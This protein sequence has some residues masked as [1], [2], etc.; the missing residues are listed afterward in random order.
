MAEAIIR[1]MLANK[2]CL[3]EM[4]VA[5]DVN[6][7]RLAQLKK[8]F[9]I[10]IQHDI[11]EVLKTTRLLLLAVKPQQMKELIE[12]MQT[13]IVPERHVLIS[14]AAGLTTELLESWLGKPVKVVRVMPNTPARF[15]CG[16]TAYCLGR[17]AGEGE[18]LLAHRIF[19][20]VGIVVR[21][22]EKNMNAITALSGS[23]PAY[24]F[25]LCEILGRA[26][27]QLGLDWETAHTLARQ[28]LYGA[29]CMLAHAADSPAA[30]R[31]A[32]T[33]PGG[34]TQAALA[35]LEDA[36][37]PDLFVKAMR[38]AQRRGEEL[39]LMLGSQS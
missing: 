27:E 17:H 21:A 30:L 16:A 8:D 14:I 23:G 18:A 33:S 34:T 22:E 32:V 24:V 20:S 36:A 39:S 5:T 29:G 31:A 4:L 7:I 1:G 38:S 25:Y 2:I 19:E 37:L 28:T 6:H 11:R 12:S 10:T 15:Q 26:G 9:R 13:E 3:P 35:V